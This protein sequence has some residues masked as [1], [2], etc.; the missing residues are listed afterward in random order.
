MLWVSQSENSREGQ[1]FQFCHLYKEG[2]RLYCTYFTDRNVRLSLK[3]LET[4]SEAAGTGRDPDQV[5]LLSI[6][7]SALYCFSH[8]P[9][10]HLPLTGPLIC[11]PYRGGSCVNLQ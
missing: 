5:S 2:Y 11:K 10:S 7:F 8:P 4:L 9:K 6:W 1:T 3:P